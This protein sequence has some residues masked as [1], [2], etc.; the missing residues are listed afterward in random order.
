M[1]TLFLTGV[2]IL[3]C[4]WGCAEVRYVKP[5]AT[6]ADFE[7]DKVACHDQVIMSSSGADVLRAQMGSPAGRGMATQSA[8]ETARRDVDECLR[9]KG[10]MPETR[11]K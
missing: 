5:G 6:E 9:G 2:G 3:V 8:G 7:A 10:W 1:K 4:S 11:S